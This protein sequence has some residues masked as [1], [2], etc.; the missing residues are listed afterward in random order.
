MGIQATVVCLNTSK[1]ALLDRW[2]LDYK[3]KIADPDLNSQE[4]SG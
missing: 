3:Q 2:T 4:K 1:I